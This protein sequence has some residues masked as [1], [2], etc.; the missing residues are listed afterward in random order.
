MKK[1]LVSLAAASL[2]V[3]SAVAADKGID[4][5]TTGQAVVYYNT[6]GNNGGKDLFTA[7]GG[8]ANSKGNFGV[9]LNLDADL[10]NDFTFGSQINYLTTL[11]LEK[12]LVNADM[13]NTNGTTGTEK[14][15]S[16]D[17]Y[18]SKLFIAKKMGKTTIKL[19]RQELPKALSPFAF[20]EGWNVFKN[21]F[22][23]GLVVNTDI[24]KTTI[25]GAYVAK[26]NGNGFGNNMSSFTDLVVSADAGGTTTVGGTAYM[27]TVQNKSLPMTTVTA[28]YYDLAKIATTLTAGD[29]G[30]NVMWL[31]AKVASKDLPMGL[32]FGLQGGQIAPDNFKAVKMAN[33]TA[34]GAKIGM[35]PIDAL[36]LS[37]AYTSISG[38]ETDANVAIRNTTGVKTPL[39]TQMIANQDWIALDSNTIMLKGVYNTGNYG[40]IILQGS[41]SDTGKASLKRYTDASS[42]SQGQDL[43]DIELVYK[44]KV[45]DVNLLAAYISQDFDKD[46]GSTAED[47]NDI[48]RFV[49]RYNF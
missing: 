22:D 36:S 4:I 24:P 25:V 20:S 26:G 44:V 14:S 9:Q 49:A 46:N 45:G 34:L 15:I 27:L 5:V 43:L 18:F 7:N 33:T 21:T 13:Q 39:Y 8:A 47:H 16:D 41:M 30:A 32:N 19:G 11:G 23:A 35:K 6:L 1:T 42:K 37:L 40:K 10:K 3:T 2:I 17:I 31:D 28:S 29:I 48:V 12:N 38:D